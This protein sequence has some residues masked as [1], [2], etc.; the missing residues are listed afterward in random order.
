MHFRQKPLL[1]EMILELKDAIFKL[2]IKVMRSFLP[3]FLKVLKG[4]MSLKIRKS[5]QL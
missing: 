5:A 3:N 1:T 2:T 4:S